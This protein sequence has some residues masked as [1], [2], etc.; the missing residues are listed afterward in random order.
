M[1]DDMLTEIAAG[2]GFLEPWM[3]RV[4]I[5][6]FVALLLDFAQRMMLARVARRA[7]RQQKVLLHA[8]VQAVIPP[9]SLTIWLLGILAGADIVGAR[10]EAVWFDYVAEIRRLGVILAM[11]WFALRLV[12]TI[13]L[14]VMERARARGDDLDQTTVDALAKLARIAIV[15]T[16]VLVAMQNLG[17]SISGVLAFGGIGGLAVGLAA[18]DL[19]ANFF[20]GFT[21]YM[22]RPFSVGD[23][24]RS[25]DRN[26]EGTV[27][28]IGWRLTRIRTFDKRPLYVPNALFTTAVLE[29]PSRMSNRRIFETIGVRYDDFGVLED[30]VAEVREMLQSHEDIETEQTLMVFFNE[31]SDSSLDF[32]I[33]CFTRTVVW[34][35]FHRVKE[36]VLFRVGRIIEKHGA[37]IAFPTRTLHVADPLRLSED[38][39]EEPEPVKRERRRR[40]AAGQEPSDER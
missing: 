15:I 12:R 23:W 20:G 10:S 35:E 14:G 16:A 37:S 24:V 21:V 31:Y 4:F 25:P 1:N 38:D 8:S 11:A 3:I 18:R 26:I 30:I 13:E 32:F 5:V 34:R 27:E 33:Y 19:L 6:I 39:G 40:A 7:E 28:Q 17:F 9:L 36:D 22:D 29:N 2:V